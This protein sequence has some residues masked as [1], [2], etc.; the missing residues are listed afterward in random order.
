MHSGHFVH[1]QSNDGWSS[2]P[3]EQTSPQ[4]SCIYPAIDQVTCWLVFFDAIMREQFPLPGPGQRLGPP[5]PS[6]A[7]QSHAH[8]IHCAIMFEGRTVRRKSPNGMVADAAAKDVA[9][10]HQIVSSRTFLPKQSLSRFHF[11]SVKFQ[12][13]KNLFDR[14]D[15]YSGPIVLM[16]AFPIN[17]AHIAKNRSPGSRPGFFFGFSAPSGQR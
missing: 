6:P 14:R 2:K 4:I 3:L 15:N 10:G 11:S 7:I 1:A 8:L 5:Q 12:L 13:Q 9:H 16:S 17:A